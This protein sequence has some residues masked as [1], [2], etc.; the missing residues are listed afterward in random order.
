MTLTNIQ[1]MCFGKFFGHSQLHWNYCLQRGIT[2]SNLDVFI[3][4]SFIFAF[5]RKEREKKNWS[6]DELEWICQQI[7]FQNTMLDPVFF[8]NDKYAYLN[9]IKNCFCIADIF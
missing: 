4:T 7:S 1:P 2:L 6:I 5:L 3:K 8:E 9:H